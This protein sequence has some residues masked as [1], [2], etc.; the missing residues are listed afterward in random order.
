MA[1][2]QLKDSLEATA[3]SQ[4]IVAETYRRFVV[5]GGLVQKWQ[6]ATGH[7]HGSPIVWKGPNNQAWL[8]VM[9]EGD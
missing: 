8:Y 6:G 2:R 7:I 9:G 5:A 1:L 3:A 4:Q